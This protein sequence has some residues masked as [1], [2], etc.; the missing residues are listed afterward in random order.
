M[1]IVNQHTRKKIDGSLSSSKL[2]KMLVIFTVVSMTTLLHLAT[3]LPGQKRVYMTRS[4]Q[5]KVKRYLQRRHREY[6]ESR[7][8]G[9][10]RPEFYT[11]T[12]AVVVDP[13]TKEVADIIAKK[14]GFINIGKVRI[15][16]FECLCYICI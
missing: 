6:F 10:T 14:H 1:M 11:N 13:P 15:M 8:P 4:G 16:Q 12:W 2:I 3:A 7:Y 5:E 9:G